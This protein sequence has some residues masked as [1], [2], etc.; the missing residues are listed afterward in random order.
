MA[1]ETLGKERFVI[2][3][4]GTVET[5]RI[6]ARRQVFALLFLPV[7]LMGWTVGGVAAINQVVHEFNLFVCVWL[8][9][10]AVGWVFAAG[11]FVWMLIGAETVRVVGK[12]LEVGV[13]IGPWMRRKLYQ[14][15]Q[16]KD[17]RAAPANSLSNFQMSGPF[18]RQMQGGAVQFTYGARTVRL[19]AG[20]DEA[21]GRLIV[22]RLKK[23]LPAGVTT[24]AAA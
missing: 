24:E 8:C 20:L 23:S 1:Y 22:E 14:G 12:D 19:A 11:T 9:G 13:E 3:R 15:A 17:L 4:S 18:M 10:W 6:K 16:I 5:I 7:W 2:D 21:E